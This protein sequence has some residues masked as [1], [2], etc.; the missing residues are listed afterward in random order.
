MIF[1]HLVVSTAGRY[2]CLKNK[3]FSLHCDNIHPSRFAALPSM[4]EYSRKSFCEFFTGINRLACV[5]KSL[6]LETVKLV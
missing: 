3:T 1:T 2:F 6:S 4:G 5:I